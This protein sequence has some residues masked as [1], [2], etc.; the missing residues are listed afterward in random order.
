MENSSSTWS[1]FCTWHNSSI[2]AS[3]FN[4]EHIYSLQQNTR[5]LWEG[6][7]ADGTPTTTTTHNGTDDEFCSPLHKYFMSYWSEFC[8]IASCSNVENSSSTWSQFCTWH[9]SSIRACT[10]FQFLAHQLFSTQG[11]CFNIKQGWTQYVRVPGWF[12]SQCGEHFHVRTPSW[13]TCWVTFTRTYIDGIL[14]KGPYPPCLRMADRTLLAGYHRYLMIMQTGQQWQWLII[15][16]TGRLSGWQP[17]YSLE[18]CLQHLLW[19]PWKSPWW[20]YIFNDRTG[21]ELSES[22]IFHVYGYDK[23]V[24]FN[25]FHWENEPHFSP[26]NDDHLYYGN[27]LYSPVFQGKAWVSLLRCTMGVRI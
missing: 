4:I 24:N 19:R 6:I 16:E 14:P 26:L 21:F 2:R 20:L 17:W 27:T 25:F 1:Q 11:A 15:T 22:H 23:G 10:R 9:D 18:A 8:K 7:E 3:D 12:P 13:V 5:L